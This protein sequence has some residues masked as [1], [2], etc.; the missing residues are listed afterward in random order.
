MSQ[1][2]TGWI[3][4][5]VSVRR[6]A[7]KTLVCAAVLGCGGLSAQ[8]I[9]AAEL[10][11]GCEPVCGCESGIAEPVCGC[12]V[13]PNT[14]CGCQSE[15]EPVCGFESAIPEM[16]PAGC[17][18]QSPSCGCDQ[19]DGGPS[20][21]EKL[22]SKLGSMRSKF[23]SMFKRN[24]SGADQSCDD[25]CDAMML[26]ELSGGMYSDTP[27]YSSSPG[28]PGTPTHSA[29]PMQ[30]SSPQMIPAPLPPSDANMMRR[31][32]AVVVPAPIRMR[33]ST[34]LQNGAPV[35]NQ[36]PLQ[37]P[38]Q[39]D[40]PQPLRTAPPVPRSEPRP[41]EMDNLFDS[42]NDPFADED[43]SFRPVRRI[44]PASYRQ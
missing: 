33:N 31:D 27:M 19:C 43:A 34:P 44:Q 5:N 39:Q 1:E 3:N 15:W 29:V 32:N 36:A 17:G 37:N 21:K 38:G 11:C 25:G 16:Q 20:R 13:E 9:T 24:R 35:Q 40:Q 4:R 42:S 6:I 2:S 30:S 26:Q 10:A 14:D 8:P 12:E 23:T 22:I 28:Y 7:L 41:S 18:C